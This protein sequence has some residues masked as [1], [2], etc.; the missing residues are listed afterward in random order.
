LCARTQ[1]GNTDIAHET[2]GTRITPADLRPYWR[3]RWEERAALMEHDGG[4]MFDQANAEALRDILAQIKSAGE[5][6]Q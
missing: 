3:E 2:I 4:M 5:P 6:T 1:P